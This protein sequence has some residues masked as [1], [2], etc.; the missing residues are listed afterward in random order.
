MEQEEYVR[1]GIK[2]ENIKYFNNKII[3]EL[4]EKKPIGKFP[5][6]LLI[7]LLIFLMEGILPLLDECCLIANADD[8]TFLEKLDKHFV[9]ND[10]YS[11]WETTKKK[12]FARDVF[13]VKHYAGDVSY[14]VNEFVAKNQDTLFRDQI[15]LVRS[16][17]D[18]L[19]SEVIPQLPLDSNKRPLTSGTKF[20][21]SLNT[22]LESLNKCSPHYVRCIKSNEKKQAL[23]ID[24]E[25]VRHQIRYLGLLEN[26]RVRRA[27]F[28]NRQEYP[29]FLSRYKMITKATWPSWNKS[30]QAGVQ[31]ILN[32]HKIP[33]EE[34]RMGK[35]KI[36]IRNPKTVKKK[37]FNFINL[38]I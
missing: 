6:F 29:R 5:F 19:I 38:E 10:R 12:E 7:S 25:R 33:D 27:G 22:L 31:A 18:K 21:N 17:K 16:S 9:K 28:C 3:C 11:S 24:E 32:D 37:T 15:S 14:K 36:F 2:W 30:P 26:V 8:K 23:V 35:T 34:Y 13:L 4:I 20:K 1:E